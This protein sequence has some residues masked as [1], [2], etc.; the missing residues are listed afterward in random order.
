MNHRAL[1]PCS[2]TLESQATP[3]YEAMKH[4]VPLFRH[5][6]ERYEPNSVC[7]CKYNQYLIVGFGDNDHAIKELMR[8]I[9]MTSKKYTQ[10][11]DSCNGGAPNYKR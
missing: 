8:F 7:M 11:D 9:D 4:V 3:Y 1:G 10:E 2:M 6:F 5:L